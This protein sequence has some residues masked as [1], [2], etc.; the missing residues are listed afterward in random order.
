MLLS[1]LETYNTV[2]DDPYKLSEMYQKKANAATLLRS[3]GW[4][5]EWTKGRLYI[6]N[7]LPPRI[8]GLP[9]V[10]KENSPLRP[11]VSTI[12]TSAYS[13]SRFLAEILGMTIDKELNVRNSF[14]F[15][16]WERGKEIPEGYVLCSLDVVNLFTNVSVQRAIGVIIKKWNLIRRF[17]KVPRSTFINMVRF[18]MVECAFFTFNDTT[19][20]QIYGTAI[21]SPLAATL[22]N[23]VMDDLIETC[24]HTSEIDVYFIRKY[25]DD[26]ILAIRPNHIDLILEVFSD[27]DERIKFTVELRR[28]WALVSWT[29]IFGG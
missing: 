6:N 13:L 24:M 23:L 25:V 21:G 26:L 9:K 1:D 8:Y 22:A 3:Q 16:E 20:R 2:A 12:G 14:D 15:V 17:T 7:A 19:Y 18:C 4:I 28:T 29:L 5:D 11:V 10:H 27:Y